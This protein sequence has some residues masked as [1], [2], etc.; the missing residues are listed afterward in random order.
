M[1]FGNKPSAKP[2]VWIGG[3]G[4]AIVLFVVIFLIITI[5]TQ[6]PQLVSKLLL[7]VFFF[8]ALA[9]GMILLC[10]QTITQI[11]E[12]KAKDAASRIDTIIVGTILVELVLAGALIET[13]V[14]TSTSKI[15]IS[16]SFIGLFAS[17]A[18]LVIGVVIGF[19][20]GVPR[21][22]AAAE[23][24]TRNAGSEAGVPNARDA[25]APNVVAPND[26]GGAVEPND[27]AAAVASGNG[28]HYE[29]NT[30]LTQISDWLTKTIVGVGLVNWK[31]ALG[32]FNRT[33]T[34]L[35]S[36]L[37]LEGSGG[38]VVGGSIILFFGVSG[39][40]CGYNLTQLFLARALA[41][42]GN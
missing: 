12:E 42:S 40:L 6:Q 29:P 39:F 31:P 4:A 14:L 3:I 8:A 21:S 32:W 23:R 2:V 41:R 16:A 15:G 30:N 36:S 17:L 5:W 19:L 26:G 22:V 27:G 25:G 34:A 35:G 9:G 28:A 1:C 18:A 37:V 7:I 24:T 13:A 20:F 33:A 10:N 38:S 11:K